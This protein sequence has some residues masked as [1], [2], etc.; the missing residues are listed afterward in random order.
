MQ[1]DILTIGTNTLIE[2]INHATGV[3]AKIDTG[4][5]SSSIWASDIHMSKDGTLSFKLF[6]E[7]S[8][9]YTGETISTQSYKVA[10]VRSSSGHEQMRYRAELSV[11]VKGRR[12]RI[13]F[14]LADR[15]RN[16][17]PI[18]IGRRSL[19]GKFV[20]DVAHREHTS[21]EDRK[22]RGLN[23]ELLQD[24]YAFHKKYFNNLNQK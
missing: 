17:F 20:V 18:L 4:A 2:I 11:R 15:S 8:P 10:L 13:L 9:F 5:D 12:L 6:A 16:A 14:N 1:K 7:G 3:P 22:K 21:D 19:K 23:E 24:P